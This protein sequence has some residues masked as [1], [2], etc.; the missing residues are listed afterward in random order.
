ME[1]ILA[2]VKK[3]LGIDNE[4]TAF[5]PDIVMFINTAFST[6]NELG[7]GDPLGFAI[8]SDGDDTDEAVWSDFLDPGPTLN[9]VKTFVYLQVRLLFDPPATSFAIQAMES[10]LQQL[11]WRLNTR[12]EG[13]D[14]VDPNP[15]VV[16][17][18]E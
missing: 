6:L 9:S 3:N 15:P 2:S 13:T 14:W 12:R 7:I 17:I 5:D 10:Q 11:A 16:I 18:D 4:Y 1:G 8:D